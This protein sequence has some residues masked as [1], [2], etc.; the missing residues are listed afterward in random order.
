MANVLIVLLIIAV[1]VGP[2]LYYQRPRPGALPGPRPG[3][4]LGSYP[5]GQ[6]YGPGPFGQ[7]R[8]L[9]P[10]TNAPMSLDEYEASR[11]ALEQ[12]IT[13]FG[14][15]LRDLDLE[16]VGKELSAEA[17]ADYTR[18][19]DAY[20]GAKTQMG[21]IQYV[22]DLK[23][24][25]EILEEGRYSVACVQSRVAGRPIPERRAP[26]FFDPGH[27]PSVADVSWAPPGGAARDVPACAADAQ[28]VRLGADPSIR[29]V[30]YGGQLQPYWENRAY[31]P[32]AQGYYGRYGLDPT[33]KSL[34][35]SALVIGGLGLLFGLLDD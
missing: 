5:G 26:C 20:D 11:A 35:S 9:T 10:P 18:A 21:R 17:N 31:A 23:R 19:L 32:Y 25:A 22:D 8:Q 6:V 13:T 16:V 34:A 24:V 15:E 3:G 29:M 1:V 2:V 7:P 12:D 4:P 30:G 27:G 33:I 14:T 28:R